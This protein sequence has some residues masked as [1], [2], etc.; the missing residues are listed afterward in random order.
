MEQITRTEP[1]NEYYYL[2]NKNVPQGPHSLTE[3]TEMMTD[4]RLNPTTL[5][6]TKGAN[7]WEPL[8]TVLSNQN[9][10]LPEVHLRPGQVGS[11]PT[12]GHDLAEDLC[13]GRL[14]GRC[15][16]CGRILGSDK[17][18]VHIWANFCMAWRNF[19]R[20]TGRATRAEFWSFQLVNLLIAMA[21]YIPF[22]IASICLAG[23]EVFEKDLTEDEIAALMMQSL[24]SGELGMAGVAFIVL[25]L[26]LIAWTLAT[27]I[28]NL[29]LTVR[30]L[31][32][33]GWSGKWLMAY[34]ILSFFLPLVLV[35]LSYTTYA[36][37]DESSTWLALFAASVMI[38]VIVAYGLAFL[39]F[40]LVLLDSKRGPNKYGPSSKYPLG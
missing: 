5:V 4:G 31:H 35:F 11:C 22:N 13:E 17:P 38:G 9:I 25:V 24:T 39:L 12:C 34:F 14:P 19:A 16:A 21:L 6:A 18:G 36:A 33:V 2:N 30:R 26:A 27:L 20:F 23:S 40:V 7:S 28:P 8:G 32:D 10:P 1:M 37:A 3:L 15:P 29:A